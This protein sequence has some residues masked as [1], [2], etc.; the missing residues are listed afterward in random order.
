MSKKRDKS[1]QTEQ[2]KKSG[3][4]TG[5][6]KRWTGLHLFAAFLIGAMFGFLLG[7]EPAGENGEET[8]AHGRSPSHPHYEHDHP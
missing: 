8:D 3:I 5:L 4:R 7:F 1:K 2:K 6:K